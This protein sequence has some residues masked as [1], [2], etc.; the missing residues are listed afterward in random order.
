M[1]DSFIEQYTNELTEDE[2]RQSDAIYQNYKDNHALT[3]EMILEG[4]FHGDAS[5][6]AE[7]MKELDDIHVKAM[8]NG[9]FQASRYSEERRM[10]EDKYFN[11]LRQQNEELKKQN[12]DLRNDFNELKTLIIEKLK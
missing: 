9:K 10:E 4:I 12:E 6:V 7:R 5:K 3:D 11:E 1:R 8:P 2:R